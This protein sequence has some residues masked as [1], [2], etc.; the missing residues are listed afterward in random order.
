V[1][2]K[3]TNGTIT[4]LNPGNYDPH[5]T[6]AVDNCFTGDGTAADLPYDVP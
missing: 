6:G 4:A 1:A 5:A 3:I 2:A